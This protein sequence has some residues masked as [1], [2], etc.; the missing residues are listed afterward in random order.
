M[1]YIVPGAPFAIAY[2][3]LA[4]TAFQLNWQSVPFEGGER[5]KKAAARRST[6]TLPAVQK[7]GRSR[8]PT[9]LRSL[10]RR[11]RQGN[12]AARTGDL[13]RP[14]GSGLNLSSPRV[15]LE[16][17]FISYFATAVHQ[18]NSSDANTPHRQ[19]A[20]ALWWKQYRDLFG[21]FI[22]EAVS[23]E[24]ARGHLDA[25]RNRLQLLSS[26]QIL[27]IN[28]SNDRLVSS[29]S[30]DGIPAGADFRA[31]TSWYPALLVPMNCIR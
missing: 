3:K 31:R 27:P 26:A 9:D 7:P 30:G 17:S 18:R 10:L 1:Q 2:A 6:L 19:L 15:Y 25:V 24:C 12:Y 4:A 20:S 23:R 11:G 16:T 13:L 29:L 28:Q 21:L 22:S 5:K 8:T 14:A